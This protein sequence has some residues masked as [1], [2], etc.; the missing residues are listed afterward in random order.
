MGSF[1]ALKKSHFGS[2]LLPTGHWQ[3]AAYVLPPD[4]TITQTW[5]EEYEVKF[6][7]ASMKGGAAQATLLTTC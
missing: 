3:L 4:K 2:N 1:S 5:T 7:K 6:S